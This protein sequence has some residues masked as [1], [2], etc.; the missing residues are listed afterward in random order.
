VET[1]E[2]FETAIE[3]VKT[4]NINTETRGREIKPRREIET[5]GVP[6]RA[7]RQS[8]G[9]AERHAQQADREYQ[10]GA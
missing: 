3:S 6:K 8:G 7:F 9:S 10:T 2:R 4:A 5:D 1:A